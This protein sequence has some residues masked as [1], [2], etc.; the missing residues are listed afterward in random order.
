M[1][2]GATTNSLS[3]LVRVRFVIILVRGP[4]G[5]GV[6]VFSTYFLPRS[7]HYIDF[8]GGADKL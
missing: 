6:S 1:P 2:S 4:H 7:S 3:S 8:S 5:K